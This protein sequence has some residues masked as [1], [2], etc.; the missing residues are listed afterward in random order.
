MSA[1]IPAAGIEIEVCLGVGRSANVGVWDTGRWDANTWGQTDTSLG[2]WVDVTC[3]TL[4]PL[5]LAA[6]A[7]GADGVVTRWEAATCSFTLIGDV[8]DPR[9]GPY[10]GLLGPG[11]PA[12]VRWRPI[13][14]Q[15]WI[16]AFT[17]Y[18]DDSG[19]TYDA[20]VTPPRAKLACTDATRILAAFDG[21]EQSPIGQGETAAQRVARIA[22]N[23]RWPADRRD[24]AAGGVAVR[25]TTLAD[26]AWT[27]LLAVADTDLALLWISRAGLLSYRPQGK[28]TPPRAIS[29]MIT[30]GTLPD[31]VTGIRPLNIV[32]QQPTITRNI[33]SIS[34]QGHD[35]EDPATV[36][37][38]DQS[39]V[40]RYLAHS[41]QRTDLVHVD[42]AWSRNVADA[43]ITSS[44]WPSDAP[45][46]V[47][48]DSRADL[49]AS[50]L[51]L[52]LEPSLSV[53]VDDGHNVW[54]C[55]PAGW[56]VTVDRLAVSGEVTLL[57]V[58]VWF[59]S[60]WDA[61]VWDTDRWGF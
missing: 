27:E 25:D 50:A 35:G 15:T 45:A 5:E 12:R 8:F 14:T 13:G 51:L 38:T 22:D 61:A 1:A 7:S 47:E 37:V 33:V 41:Y 57:D 28:V 11:L 36:T 46:S 19:F 10:A 9:S 42:D 40:A 30:C 55:E 17:G 4:T 56:K 58:S 49:A 21:V 23:A 32:G 24:I 43:V 54:Q 2:D 39:S 34:R 6:G 31:G 3:Q 48:L 16:V 20:K 53:A 29:A 26:V 18:V 44:A 52:S 60:A 59:G